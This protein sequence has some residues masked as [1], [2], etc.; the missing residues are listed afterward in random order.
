MSIKEKKSK[1]FNR[2]LNSKEMKKQIEDNVYEASEILK[3]TANDIAPIDNGDLRDNVSKPIQVGKTSFKVI[4]KQPYAGKVYRKNNKN[5]Q[6][7]KWIEK[8]YNKKKKV[9]DNTM[10]RGVLE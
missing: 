4:W 8:G 5:P 9:L 2:N 7:T 10:T 1:N 3:H 6:T